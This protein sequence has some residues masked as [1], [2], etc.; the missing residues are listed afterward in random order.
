MLL[1]YHPK[2]KRSPN[3]CKFTFQPKS[4]CDQHSRDRV[5]SIHTQISACSERV[6]ALLYSDRT[7]K[8]GG[9]DL[10]M[11]VGVGAHL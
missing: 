6:S 2:S 3:F 10:D 4:Q 9:E 11:G 5:A 1:L 8:S 7:K